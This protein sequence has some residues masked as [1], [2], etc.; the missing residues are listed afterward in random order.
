MR[1]D[2]NQGGNDLGRAINGMIFKDGY[3]KVRAF[4]MR[5]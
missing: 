1:I 2:D 3:Q 5:L 4:G